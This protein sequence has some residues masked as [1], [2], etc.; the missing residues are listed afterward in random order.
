MDPITCLWWLALQGKS[1]AFI[2]G[3]IL[4]LAAGFVL[5]ALVSPYLADDA[6]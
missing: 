6:K 2:D 1:F 3:L 4:G 5:A